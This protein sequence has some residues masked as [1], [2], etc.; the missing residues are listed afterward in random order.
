MKRILYLNYTTKLQHFIWTTKVLKYFTKQLHLS[1][2]WT[3][4]CVRCRVSGREK[5]QGSILFFLS[6]CL[7][8]FSAFFPSSVL[9]SS[10]VK[11]VYAG[12]S[13]NGHE[14]ARKS[15]WF[16]SLEYSTEPISK[17]ELFIKIK[18]STPLL[19]LGLTPLLLK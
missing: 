11:Q 2:P 5:R 12:M 4:A 16:Y 19:Y 9:S 8:F 1:G 18:H 15:S 7:P 10:C 14:F 13:Q 3:C 17:T 6:F